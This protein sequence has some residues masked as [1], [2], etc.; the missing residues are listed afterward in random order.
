MS[1]EGQVKEAFYAG[2]P[3]LGSPVWGAGLEPVWDPF[4]T[5]LGDGTPRRRLAGHQ[6]YLPLRAERTCFL[7]NQDRVQATI[8]VDAQTLQ[9]TTVQC[10]C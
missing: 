8:M 7:C 5:R 6:R 9:P 10:R 3:L 4:G 2:P 1:L